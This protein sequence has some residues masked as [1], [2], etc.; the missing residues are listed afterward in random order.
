MQ[1]GVVAL[2][3][4]KFRVQNDITAD[5]VFEKLKGY[6]ADIEIEDSA[7]YIL[8]ASEELVYY[9]ICN[10]FE[11]DKVNLIIRMDATNSAFALT[12]TTMELSSLK[13]AAKIED[14]VRANQY[15]K[16]PLKIYL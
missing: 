7:V 14:K 10:I 16:Y 8:K 9:Y 6:K 2:L 15:N 5:N 4:E 3:D 1:F 13:N 11:Q 12:P